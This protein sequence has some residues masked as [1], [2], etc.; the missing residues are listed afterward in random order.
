VLGLSLIEM[1]VFIIVLGVGFAGVSVL[2]NQATTSSVDPLVRKQV[3]AIA[4]SLLE[5]IQLRGFTFCDPDDANVYTATTA[6]VGAGTTN[7]ATKA[8]APPYGPDTTPLD[9]AAGG[10]ATY[11]NV[12]DYQGFQ[13]LSGI[14]DIMG[15]AVPGLSA[16]KITGVT[17]TTVTNAAT[18]FSLSNDEDLLLIA[19]T[20]TGPPG[21]SVTLQGYRFRYAPNSP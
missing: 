17:V 13:L 21:V 4:T 2:Y 7:C 8:E 11:D 19:V 9:E 15:T 10:R 12:N 16:Y 14:T 5:E 18:T 20:V 6:A 3:L 1:V